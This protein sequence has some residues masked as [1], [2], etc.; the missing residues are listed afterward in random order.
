M[1]VVECKS[2]SMDEKLLENW[3]NS[4]E[5]LKT[6]NRSVVRTINRIVCGEKEPV[7]TQTATRPLRILCCLNQEYKNLQEIVDFDVV[8]RAGEEKLDI[9]WSSKAEN[10][11]EWYTELN[12]AQEEKTL[13]EEE[14]QESV[15]LQK[16]KDQKLDDY[17]VKFGEEKLSLMTFN[18]QFNQVLMLI[19][20]PML[21]PHI[22][23]AE[24][25]NGK[26][27][28]EAKKEGES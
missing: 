19:N 6:S 21:F 2:T 1:A 3:I 13:K 14:K 16:A 26:I 4:I 27:G 7:S 8:I 12:H 20:N 18:F 17:E 9:E 11:Y 22:A 23:Y 5:Q 24:M 15:S 28:E 10:L 25:F